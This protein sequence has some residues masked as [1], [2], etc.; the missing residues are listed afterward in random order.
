M[1]RQKFRRFWRRSNITQ[2]CVGLLLL[3]LTMH[4]LKLLLARSS[5]LPRTVLRK[6]E[7]R[8]EAE[9]H[10]SKM[11][12]FRVTR[13][14]R[15]PSGWALLQ[16]SRN[17][18]SSGSRQLKI[19]LISWVVASSSLK[20]KKKKSNEMGRNTISVCKRTVKCPGVPAELNVSGSMLTSFIR[21][22]FHSGFSLQDMVNRK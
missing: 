5:T 21:F 11:E 6:D 12:S 2:V 15:Q 19:S 18:L 14:C 16:T 20:K 13:I 8:D 4:L 3:T 22:L 17:P 1:K 10:I 7:G 9:P